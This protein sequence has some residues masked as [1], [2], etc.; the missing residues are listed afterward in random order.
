MAQLVAILQA[1]TET[2]KERAEAVSNWLW[3]LRPRTPSEPA[4]AAAPDKGMDDHSDEEQND[5]PSDESG[6]C[7]DDAKGNPGSKRK[8]QQE[9][10]TAPLKK[11]RTRKRAMEGIDLANGWTSNNIRAWS[12]CATQHTV[13]KSKSGGSWPHDRLASN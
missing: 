7:K 6:S 11:T 8:D 3:C 2:G 12:Q 9:P 1:I 4:G 10:S 13:A 5:G